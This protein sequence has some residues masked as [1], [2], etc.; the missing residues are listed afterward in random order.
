ML[1]NTSGMT[2][3]KITTHS[4]DIHAPHAEF[5]LV[6]Q[7][8]VRPQ[9]LAVDRVAPGIDWLHACQLTLHGC[10][11][12]F[13]SVTLKYEANLTFWRRNYFFFKF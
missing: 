7:A 5:E 13:T 2:H 11:T 1:M 8:S 10:A 9:T 6:I 12:P 3:L 4:T